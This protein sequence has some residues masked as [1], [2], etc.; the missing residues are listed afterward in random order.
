M[1]QPVLRRG[2]ELRVWGGRR[3]HDVPPGESVH[4][5]GAG[6]SEGTLRHESVRVAVPGAG[7]AGSVLRARDGT[8]GQPLLLLRKDLLLMS[9]NAKSRISVVATVMAAFA[10]FA[11][12]A[13]STGYRLPQEEETDVRAKLISVGLTK[14]VL[15]G[16]TDKWEACGEYA[17]SFAAVDR[18]GNVVMGTVCCVESECQVRY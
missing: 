3:D 15:R 2:R 10:A 9:P 4:V 5:D 17:R 7:S 18:E 12:I 6:I 11:A 1:R 16:V 8:D 14:I 13:A